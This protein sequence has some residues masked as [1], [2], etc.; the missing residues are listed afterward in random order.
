MLWL[1][2]KHTVTEGFKDL[3][4]DTVDGSGH[5]AGGWISWPLVTL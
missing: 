1:K 4:W 5:Q 2:G 3:T